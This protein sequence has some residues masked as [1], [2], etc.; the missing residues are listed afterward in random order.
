MGTFLSFLFFT[1]FV[2]VVTYWRTHR[3]NLHSSQGY[4]LG[5]NSLSGWVIAGSLLLTNLSA[6][7]ITG[8][9]AQVYG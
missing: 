4:F 6:A 1:S 3:E 5:G 9:T 2:A 7:N 8:M